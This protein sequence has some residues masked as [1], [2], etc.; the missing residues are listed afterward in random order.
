MKGTITV[1]SPDPN[2]KGVA[3]LSYEL[4][5][6]YKQCITKE[7]YASKNAGKLIRELNMRLAGFGGNVPTEE[8]TDRTESM[9]KQFQRDYMDAPQTGK[10]CGPLLKAVDEFC[11]KYAETVQDYAC[12]CVQQSVPNWDKAKEEARCRG[13]G[14]TVDDDRVSTS[15]R[16]ADYKR[17][18]ETHGV[19]KSL[20]WLISACRF[21]LEKEMPEYKIHGVERGYR[22]WADNDSHNRS[23]GNHFG[24]AADLHISKNGVEIGKKE[25]TD[26]D[27]IRRDIFCKH[28]NA[29]L[30]RKSGNEFGWIGGHVGLES[31]RDK[32]T[33]WIHVDVRE[34]PDFENPDL[35]IT[36]QADLM[37]TTLV[38]LA[39][40]LGFAK[41][42]DCEYKPL[43]Y[44]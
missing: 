10:I 25:R 44:K 3:Y 7:N 36:R 39:N 27:R 34:F 38:D 42:S 37:P 9:I 31:F 21:Y 12:P 11:G 19:H 5:Y 20:L 4:C 30:K 24:Y 8:F 26:F 32:A 43:I 22:C 6:L 2:V 1:S 29:P 35:F 23:S 33:S 40:E 16:M 13:W 17:L 41:M 28:M 15:V 18:K 14:K